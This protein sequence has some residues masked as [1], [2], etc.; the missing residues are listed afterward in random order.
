MSWPFRTS[1]SAQPAA[2]WLSVPTWA[3]HWHCPGACVQNR[4]CCLLSA[5]LPGGPIAGRQQ[6][7]KGWWLGLLPLFSLVSHRPPP[8]PPPPQVPRTEVSGQGQSLPSHPC[9]RAQA[10]T[11]FCF[12]QKRWAASPGC[13][14]GVEIDPSHHSACLS[15]AQPSTALDLSF[16]LRPIQ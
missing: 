4:G 6:A 5:F 15:S 8:V 11:D 2:R 7:Q 13:C 14:L 10:V 16:D 3:I 12:C 1:A 9:V